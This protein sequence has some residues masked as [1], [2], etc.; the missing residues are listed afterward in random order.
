LSGSFK[1]EFPCEDSEQ[2]E[3]DTKRSFVAT[4]IADVQ[5]LNGRDNFLA[6]SGR[7]DEDG[8]LLNPNSRRHRR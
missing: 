6:I 1:Q 5:N 3:D 2:E 8:L 7:D 4:F